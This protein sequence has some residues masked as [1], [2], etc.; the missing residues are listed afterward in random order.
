MRKRLVG[1]VELPEERD[2]VFPDTIPEILKIIKT[3]LPDGKALHIFDKTKTFNVYVTKRKNKYMVQLIPHASKF[4]DKE[5]GINGLLRSLAALHIVSAFSSVISGE[6]LFFKIED[7]KTEKEEAPEGGEYIP[8]NARGMLELFEKF[9]E[10]KK[11]TFFNNKEG[12]ILAVVKHGGMYKIGIEDSTGRRV[13]K[14]VD[15][16]GIGPFIAIIRS[17]DKEDDRVRFTIDFPT[18]DDDGGAVVAE[19]DESSEESPEHR[20]E[21]I[22]AIMLL[23][24]FTANEAPWTYEEAAEQWDLYDT[25]Q[26]INTFRYFTQLRKEGIT[27]ILYIR[28]LP[29]THRNMDKATKMWD[30]LPVDKQIKI[31]IKGVEIINRDK[32][33]GIG[34]NENIRT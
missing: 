7:Y 11:V 18:D 6:E 1:E 2:Q 9:P 29:V 4:A 28:G 21:G 20:E 10:D 30:S 17:K 13:R 5:V 31:I 32:P 22:K 26:K 3:K 19:D 12:T 27:A 24:Q 23:Q 16:R 25:N 8:D 14:E 15:I 33:R 34:L